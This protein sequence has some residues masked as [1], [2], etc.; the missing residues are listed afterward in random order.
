[1]LCKKYPLFFEKFSSLYPYQ[2]RALKNIANRVNSLV[3]APT[4][5]GKSL[6]FQLGALESPGTT[7][8]VSPLNALISEQTDFLKNRGVNVLKLTG[9]I[10]FVD[11]RRIYR[12]LGKTKPKIIYLSPERLHNYFFRAALLRS[13]LKISMIAID[14]AHCISQWGIDFRPEYGQIKPFIQF[15]RENEHDPVVI[16]MTATL[17][18]NARKDIVKEFDVKDGNDAVIIEKDLIRDELILDFIPVDKE[19]EKEQC[20]LGILREHSP[21]K[22][23]VYFYSKDKCENFTDLLQENGF[24]ADYFHADVDTDEKAKVYNH[25]LSGSINVLCATSAFGMGMNIPDI[26][27]VIHH[28]IPGSV[29]EY[30]QQVGRAARDKTKCPQAKCFLLWSEKNF[31]HKENEHINHVILSPEKIVAAFKALGLKNKAGQ[32]VSIEYKDYKRQ[33]LDYFRF[34]FERQGILETIG[35]LNGTPKTIKFKKPIITWDSIL[36]N[37]G[38]G[39]SYI[40][41]ASNSNMKLIDLIDYI[42]DQELAGNIEKFPALQKKVFFRSELNEIP[43]DKQYEIV[44][45]SMKLAEYKKELLRDLHRLVL[46]DDPITVIKQVLGKSEV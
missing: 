13:G 45:E 10:K 34:V 44:R 5:K 25:F 24:S 2:E 4:G 1:M 3:V 36:K 11:Q 33:G 16:A 38:I 28:I 15:L 22:A 20:M 7:I 9:E 35:E 26:D 39:N 21:N 12:E 31:T 40:R 19:N 23:I 37:M 14:E 29:E 27:M 8:V 42:L 32:F 6:I 46:A 17:G 43:I 18:I 41:A 30:Y